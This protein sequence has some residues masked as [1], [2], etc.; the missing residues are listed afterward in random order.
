MVREARSLDR[1]E[2]MP[3]SNDVTAVAWRPLAD[4]AW[5]DWLPLE[6]EP[7]SLPMTGTRM[8]WCLL[9][10]GWSQ[11][12]LARRIHT[13]ESS[14]RQ[15]V[16]G[17]RDI[18]DTLA[19]WLE[20]QVSRMLCGPMKPDGWRAKPIWEGHDAGQTEAPDRRA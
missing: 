10:I 13:H 19:I 8:R 7:A 3:K 2:S 4:F 18:P 5:P 1:V 20:R 17:R 15:M 16:R 9:A 6:S 11:E 12:E 14:V